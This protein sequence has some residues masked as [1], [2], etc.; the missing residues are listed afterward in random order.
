MRM[1]SV[2][3]RSRVL[4]DQEVTFWSLLGVRLSEPGPGATVDQSDDRAIPIR[5]VRHNRKV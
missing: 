2:Q 5:P 4:G 1:L 3:E